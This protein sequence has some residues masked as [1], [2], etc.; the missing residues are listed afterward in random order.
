MAF[1]L[2]EDSAHKAE[3]VIFPKLFA[4]IES[5]LSEHSIFAIRG[6]VESTPQSIKIKAQAL[7]PIDRYIRFRNMSENSLRLPD[8][9]EQSLLYDLKKALKPGPIPVDISFTERATRLTVATKERIILDN[10]L[11]LALKNL[12][13]EAFIKLV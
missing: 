1:A 12:K 2:F 9:L 8:A 4:Q 5:L 10:E 7:I 6:Q 11:L 3:V 13:V